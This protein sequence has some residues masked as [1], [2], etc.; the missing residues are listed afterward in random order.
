[1]AQNERGIVLR[2]CT[3][4]LQDT[5]PTASERLTTMTAGTGR[6]IIAHRFLRHNCCGGGR[7]HQQFRCYVGSDR[8]MLRLGNPRLA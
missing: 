1:M 6:D 3:N 4:D 2:A 5:E 8:T 7:E